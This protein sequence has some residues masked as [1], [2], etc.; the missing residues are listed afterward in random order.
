MLVRKA[1]KNSMTPD[2]ASCRSRSQ[3]SQIII[4]II[5]QS[6]DVTHKQTRQMD[7]WETDGWVKGVEEVGTGTLRAL[8]AGNNMEISNDHLN[9]STSSQ[10]SGLK[11]VRLL[12]RW[13]LLEGARALKREHRRG[14]ED[15]S[16]LSVAA[17]DDAQNENSNPQ[18]PQQQDVHRL[19]KWAR[20]T[21]RYTAYILYKDTVFMFDKIC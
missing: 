12:G 1:G 21:Y 16:K 10:S 2:V 19:S 3:S 8:G 4:I 9:P 18:G 5:W 17:C 20:A 13:N 7:W 15:K 6:R 14:T 11:S